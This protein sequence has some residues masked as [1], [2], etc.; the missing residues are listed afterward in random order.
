MGL[1][2]LVV[3]QLQLEAVGV[4]EED[5]FFFGGTQHQIKRKRCEMTLLN[6]QRVIQVRI[7]TKQWSNLRII[8][9]SVLRV[10]RRNIEDMTVGRLFGSAA[11]MSFVKVH[12]L[13]VVL[14]DLVVGC[15]AQGQVVQARVGLVVGSVVAGRN[16][17][18][19]TE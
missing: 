7:L 1:V 14:V 2:S 6:Q 18:H 13:G 11:A 10:Q 8:V 16:A 15:G 17:N 19:W 12:N 5:T 9:L 4:S 3:D